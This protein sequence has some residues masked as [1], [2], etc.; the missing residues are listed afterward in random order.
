MGK[1]TGS[2]IILIGFSTTGKTRVGEQVARRLG[3]ELVDTD[4]RIVSMA[5]K[6]IDRIFAEDGEMR[7]R[8]YERLA[9]K[10]ACSRKQT[11]FACGGGVVVD[12][13]N[14]EMM[15]DSGVVILLE[16]K[17]E[18]IYN[19]LVSDKGDEVRPLLA[20]D[21]PMQ[22][23]RSLK[24]KRQLVYDE[25]SDWTICTDNLTINEVSDEV[26]RGWHYGISR[27]GN[28][29]GADMS[30]KGASS[31]VVTASGC[32]PIFVGYGLLSKLGA[33]LKDANLSGMVSIISDDNVFKLYG[34]N[35]VHTLQ[36]S[37]FDVG[38][39]VVPAGEQSKTYDTAVKIYDW[40]VERRVERDSAVVA[41]GGGMVGDLAGFVAATFLRGLPLV[42]VPTSLLAM[43][44]ASI[45]GKVAVDHPQGK[46]LI[47]SF[48]QPLLVL[49][50]VETLN[51]L[52]PRELTSGWAELIKHALILDA[53]LFEF[54]IRLDTNVYLFGSGPSKLEEVLEEAVARSAA[55][56]AWVVSLDEKETG[57]RTILNYGHT[58]AH[59]L[60]AAS[61]YD[62]FL[63]GEA[64][65]IGMMGAAIISQRL[66]LIA[67]DVI[68]R[69]R[70]LLQKFGLPTSCNDV[71]LDRVLKAMELDKKVRKKAIRWVLLEGI[72]KV[73]V[74][75]DVPQQI[76]I[77]VVKNLIEG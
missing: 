65:A 22:N 42:H 21:D 63:H 76:I 25:A 70:M 5:G 75:D 11:V 15:S 16:A 9:L 37:G 32:Y 23:I 47:G 24:E 60:E 51:T 18:T 73:V 28:M 12:P 6:P 62:R 41:L 27:K 58:I 34:S 61:G 67:D 44:D 43:V 7:F 45:G 48:Y 17:P 40:V 56:K 26:I 3:W 8:E 10:E 74:R 1:T 33:R 20:G 46:N 52:L 29:F 19:R 13:K 71:D 55:I 35:I 64:V 14:R 39:Y 72:G 36:K 38:S 54:L 30:G 49:S 4:S 50:D 2:N 69:Q 66:G 31:V 59:G 77:D 57:L 53:D 68:N